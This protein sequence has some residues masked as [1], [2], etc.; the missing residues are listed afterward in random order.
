MKSFKFRLETLLKFRKMQKEQAQIL[1]WQATNQFR[2]EKEK[3]SNLEEDV[4]RNMNLLRNFQQTLLSI[5]TF[6]S[7]QH[8]FDKMKTEIQQQKDS[9]KRADEYRLEC[10][11]KLEDA[12]K[13]HTIVEKFREKKIQDYQ[14]ELLKE[15]QKILDEIGLQLYVREE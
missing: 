7:F 8:Y 5:E 9:V 13:G 12:V 2:I 11:K 4:L 14:A 15:E 6:K 3:L 1:F 10:L